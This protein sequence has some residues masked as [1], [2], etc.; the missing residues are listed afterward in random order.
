LADNVTFQ[1]SSY[2]TAPNETVVAT[3][4]VDG[5]DYQRMKL[6]V[7]TDGEALFDVSNMNPLPVSLDIADRILKELKAINIQ[8]SL[9]TDT[10]VGQQ[11][12]E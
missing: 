8:L 10:M 9:I 7:G 12:V 3:D 1:S 11:E 5:V 2:A 4:K 6:V